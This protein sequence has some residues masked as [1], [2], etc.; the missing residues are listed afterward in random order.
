MMNSKQSISTTPTTPSKTKKANVTP[1]KISNKKFDFCNP[2]C[3]NEVGEKMETWKQ[4]R[5]T[6]YEVSNLGQVRNKETKEIK[7]QTQ[8]LNGK[9]ENDYKYVSLTINSEKC[10]KSVH[11]MDAECFIEN[12]DN[13]PE[14]NHKNGIRYDNRVENLEWCSREE[15]YQDAIRRGSNNE[16]KPVKGTLIG[17][18]QVVHFQ[19]LWQAAKYIK[20][21]KE[22]KSSI[23]T[24]CWGIN[25]N[26]KGKARSAYGYVWEYVKDVK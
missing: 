11:R 17:A 16:R 10:K 1:K 4:Y 23:D 8:K 2:L 20:T 6:N 24:I 5:E 15:N 22:L 21:S 13:L 9:R 14:V 19:S 18:I 3:Y 7:S 12:P 25:Q 26:I